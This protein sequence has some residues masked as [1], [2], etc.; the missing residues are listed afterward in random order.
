MRAL[1]EGSAVP[2]REIASLAGV[3][4][5]TV[6]KYAA[7]HAWKPRYAWTPD[8]RAAA[9]LARA[10]RASR[11]PKAPAAASSAAPTRASRLRSGSRP[12]MRESAARAAAD[13][14]RAQAIAARAEAEAKIEGLWRENEKAW[15]LINQQ[16]DALMKYRAE[17]DKLPAW[18]RPKGNDPLEG[19]YCL[20]I[21][22]ALD[23]ARETLE[24]HAAASAA[25]R[26]IIKAEQEASDE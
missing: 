10:A 5:R 23:W 4:E 15:R 3:T 26:E 13:C 18:R 24:E 1:Y 21:Q 12:P 25:L 22:T 2:V 6:Y 8:G 20:A 11:R 9:R 7:K 17:R 16:L 14:K 19:G